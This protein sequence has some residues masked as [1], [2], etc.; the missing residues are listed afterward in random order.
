M[1]D[2]DF[3]LK[4][5]VAKAKTDKE[6]KLSDFFSYLNTTDSVAASGINTESQQMLNLRWMDWLNWKEGQLRDTIK[7]TSNVTERCAVVND[8]DGLIQVYTQNIPLDQWVA[9]TGT[10][11]VGIG[12]TYFTGSKCNVHSGWKYTTESGFFNPNERTESEYIKILRER[13]DILLTESDWTRMDDNQLSSDKKVEWATYRQA[14][15]DLPANTADP[16]NP[17]F[18]TKPS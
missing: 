13:R 14:L 10:T 16:S 2:Q 3:G 15:R 5:V 7:D 4:E 18:P 9:P 8:S 12:S 17:T 1:A 11:V 6:S